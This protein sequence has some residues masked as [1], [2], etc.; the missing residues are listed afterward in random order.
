MT[1]LLLFCAVSFLPFTSFAK[2]GSKLP[3]FMHGKQ[4]ERRPSSNAHNEPP[5]DLF[6]KTGSKGTARFANF[7]K[8]QVNE[9]PL[10]KRYTLAL[11][12]VTTGG[13]QLLRL[14]CPKTS[15]KVVFGGCE[16][17]G[18]NNKSY[19][20]AFGYDAE[21]SAHDTYSDA[22]GPTFGFQGWYCSFRGLKPENLVSVNVVCSE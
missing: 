18:E 1:K 10:G 4:M 6:P 3:S 21:L 22:S 17:Y 20:Q 2:E 12:L 16:T 15:S 9:T 5:F 14:A 19:L 8:V 7:D 13:D 11:E